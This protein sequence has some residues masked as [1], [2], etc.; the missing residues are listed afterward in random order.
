MEWLNSLPVV[1]Q[2]LVWV[3]AMNTCLWGLKNGVDMIKDKTASQVDNKIAA[4]LG[5]VL[6]LI[7]K[8][9]DVVGMNPAHK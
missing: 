8:V 4:G 9:L 6:G 2:A 5:K 7:S 1:Q 3:L